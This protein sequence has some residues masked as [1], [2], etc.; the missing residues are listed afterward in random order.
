ME[1]NTIEK[2]RQKPLSII[3]WIILFFPL[4]LYL[5]WKDSDNWRQKP[6]GIIFWLILFYP[7]GLF[8]MWKHSHWSKKKKLIITGIYI[9][10]TWF[11][12]LIFNMGND[13]KI[14]DNLDQTNEEQKQVEQSVPLNKAEEPLVEKTEERKFT[15]DD[16]L[17][18]VQQYK[19]QVEIPDSIIGDTIIDYYNR[20][21]EIP[22][23]QNEGWYVDETNEKEKYIVGYVV[24]IGV[25]E[26]LPRWEVTADSIIALN[27]AAI[28]L[29]PELQL[30][31]ESN[32]ELGTATENQ[33]FDYAKNLYR[34]Y[35]QEAFD[36][37]DANPEESFEIK[38]QRLIDAEERSTRETAQYFKI[39]EEEVVKI[40]L[41]L[42]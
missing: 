5:L 38:G 19:L 4:G 20:R 18:K 21:G 37:N 25:M 39:S 29:T 31:K 16:A 36:L 35:E 3:F 42:Q 14:P 26:N 41:K 33:I 7:A 10:L 24:K 8:L 30:V 40:I 6:L 9:V 27:G 22:A 23:I 2:K 13:N 15:K 34:K 17:K 11:T 28:R 12:V 1:S 32:K